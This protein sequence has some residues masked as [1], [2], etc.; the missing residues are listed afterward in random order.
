MWQSHGYVLPLTGLTLSISQSEK[1]EG[2]GCVCIAI[3]ILSGEIS[4]ILYISFSI[5]YLCPCSHCPST[6]HHLY[7]SWHLP[8]IVAN[9]AELAMSHV[10]SH[11]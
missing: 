10:F 7:L 4:A 5:L 1:T 6:T 9:A 11:R 8:T 2:E 3:Y